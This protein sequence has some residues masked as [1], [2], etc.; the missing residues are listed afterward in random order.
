[1]S[2]TLWINSLV[3]LNNVSCAC[4]QAKD[5][6]SLRLGGEQPGHSIEARALLSDCFAPSSLS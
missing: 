5:W 2:T 4:S 3:H 1:M 6:A